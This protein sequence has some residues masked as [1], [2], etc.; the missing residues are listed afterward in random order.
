M[1]AGTRTQ[2]QQQGQRTPLERQVKV[3]KNWQMALARFRRNWLAMVGVVLALLSIVLAL[4]AYAVAPYD[5]TESD[6]ANINAWPSAQHL[7]GT[8]GSGADIFSIT[9]TALRTSYTVA[10]IA[11]GITLL[12]GMAVGMIAG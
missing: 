12:A 6:F 11:Q 7:F 8:D 9:I 4:L 5:P 10:F 2:V 1:E 3:R